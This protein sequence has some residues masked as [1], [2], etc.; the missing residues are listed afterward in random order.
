MFAFVIT[1]ATVSFESIKY[2]VEEGVGNVELTLS[3]NQA[4][5]FNASL[6]LQTIDDITDGELCSVN[7]LIPQ[8]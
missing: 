6:E 1:E 4:V 5:P 2:E 8:Y 7:I 3:L